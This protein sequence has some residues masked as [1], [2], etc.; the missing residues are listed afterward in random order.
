[1]EIC[2][3]KNKTTIAKGLYR[4]PASDGRILEIK[5]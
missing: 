2:Q 4:A 3:I 5:A 1:M